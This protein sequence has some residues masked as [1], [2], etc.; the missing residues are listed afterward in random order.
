MSKKNDSWLQKYWRPMMA[1]AYMAI[2]LFDFIVAP[3]LWSILQAMAAGTVTLQWAPLTLLSGGIF[4]AAMGAV[5][6]ISAFTRGQEKIERLR[7]S[8]QEGQS[9]SEETEENDRQ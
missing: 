1:V 2:I 6:G 4:H 8:Y 7:T 9:T 5:L 3:I